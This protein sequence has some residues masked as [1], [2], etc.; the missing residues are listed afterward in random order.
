MNITDTTQTNILA[1]VDKYLGDY[2]HRASMKYAEYKLMGES[3]S[4]MC[5]SY[6]EDMV[7]LSFLIKL[8]KAYLPLVQPFVHMEESC[9]Q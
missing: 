1:K 3:Q 2:F 5:K 8:S 6:E 7:V 9:P 4:Y